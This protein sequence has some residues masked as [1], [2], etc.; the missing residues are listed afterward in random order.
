MTLPCGLITTRDDDPGGGGEV[1]FL[2]FL[3]NNTFESMEEIRG[4]SK[5]VIGEDYHGWGIG[6]INGE[7]RL[8]L[9]ACVLLSGSLAEGFRKGFPK[10]FRE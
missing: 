1:W 6:G 7:A 8:P 10:G 9:G 5:A 2:H 4:H 3:Q